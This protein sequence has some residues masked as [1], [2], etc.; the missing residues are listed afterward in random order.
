MKKTFFITILAL[1]LG[2]KIDAQIL[3]VTPDTVV[4]GQTLDVNVTAENVDFTQGTNIVRLS[5]G[6]TTII[7][8]GKTIKSSTSLSL[9]YFFSSDI[10][11]GFYNMTIQNTIAGTTFTKNDAIYVKEI[12]SLDSISPKTAKQGENV[13]IT[14]YGDSTNFSKY[15]NAVC[16]IYGSYTYNPISMNVI[17]SKTLQA[18]FNLTYTFTTGMYDLSVQ[19]D[20]DGKISLSDAFELKEGPLVPVILSVTPDTVEQGQT[21]DIEV[22]AE[23]IDFTQGSNI[24]HI[25][26]GNNYLD[27]PQIKTSSATSLTLNC[28][29]NTDDNIGYY[30]LSI[31]NSTSRITLTKKNAI[32]VKSALDSGSKDLSV[33]PN[34]AL[35]GEKIDLFI[36]EIGN[37]DSTNTIYLDN[38]DI[39]IYP[40]TSYTSDTLEPTEFHATFT[41]TYDHPVGFY[42]VYFNDVII[43]TFELKKGTVG[44]NDISGETIHFY[45]N[46]ANDYIYL[47]EKFETIQLFNTKGQIILEAKQ[48]D[49]LNISKF[50]SGVY[51]I[52]LKT[53]NGII[54]QKLIIE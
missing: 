8:N 34:M 41:F 22:T 15:I 42:S 49:V 31:W 30:D 53:D 32:Y 6:N 50:Q 12:A 33:E 3:T 1:I 11:T 51:F 48:E 44:L 9:H 52:K 36:L 14:I 17:D 19:N 7:E 45:P 29:I 28:H 35:Q 10:P 39:K 2:S 23:N 21:L 20:V 24:V 46:P 26:N 25:F 38:G 5:H 4:I 13:T 47:K 16:L 43:D 40:I 27:Y 54:F 18:T 37:I